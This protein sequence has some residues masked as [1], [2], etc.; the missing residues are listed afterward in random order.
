[1]IK[2]LIDTKTAEQLKRLVAD[3]QH[4]VIT[5]HLSPDG[6]A[7]GSTQA[8]GRVLRALG[9]TDTHVVT[10]DQLPQSLHFLEQDDHVVTFTHNPERARYLVRCADLVFCLD[11]NALHRIDRLGQ[12]IMANTKAPRVLIDHH[13]D[14]EPLF[15]VVVS[16][17]EL[18]ST[19]ELVYRVLQQLGWEQ[20]VDKTAASYLYAGLITDTGNFAYSS[21]YPEVFEVAAQLVAR[22]ID[23]LKIYNLAMNTYSASSLRLQGYALSEK[24]Q[25]FPQCET[26]L[27]TLSKAELER[28]NYQK[29]DTEG[30]VNKPL[31]I[32][33]IRRSIF[34]RE[35]PDVVKVSC[36]S[37][38][39]VAV[40][41]LCTR[42]FGGGGHRNAAGGEFH[43][44][45]EQ[46]VQ[47][48][49]QIVN[50]D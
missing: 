6:D 45:L 14:P 20:H 29:G 15:S 30:L 16:H 11:F 50:S 12:Y 37:Q 23:K 47:V 44:T 19:C 2:P 7:I 24:M 4:I 38:D 31:A 34:L 40:N 49:M 33:A 35:D 27:I 28:F 3:A 9:K 41:D 10:P 13:L 26:A 18:S 48:V 17:P 25:L 43:G 8:L 21:E 46:A 39:E 42:Y 22:G 1:M 36:R 5:C 32:P